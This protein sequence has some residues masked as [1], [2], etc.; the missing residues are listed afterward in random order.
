MTEHESNGNLW[1]AL[2]L[3]GGFTRLEFAHS[4][5]ASHTSSGRGPGPGS[6]GGASKTAFMISSAR[7][8]SVADD[9]RPAQKGGRYRASRGAVVVWVKTGSR[10]GSHTRRIYGRRCGQMLRF[11]VCGRGGER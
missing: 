10:L 11:C 8:L 7:R 1:L 6:P 4:S 2:T 3:S 9:D 5:M